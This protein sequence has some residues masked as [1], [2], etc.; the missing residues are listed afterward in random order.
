M[1]LVTCPDCGKKHSDQAKSCPECGRPYSAP[2]P[3]TPPLPPAKK[4]GGCL[5]TAL[6][7]V[8]LLLLVGIIAGAFQ[9]PAPE[10]V[11]LAP[12]TP[13]PEAEP[14]AEPAPAAPVVNSPQ[15]A[16]PEATEPEAQ[17]EEKSPEPEFDFTREDFQ[18]R[19]NAAAKE[20][21]FQYQLVASKSNDTDPAAPT[22]DGSIVWGG[23]IGKNSACSVFSDAGSKKIQSIL[24]F[25]GG[26][27]TQQDGLD[28]VITLGAII[29]AMS[30]ELAPDQ[31]RGVLEELN[32]LPTANFGKPAN[33]TRGKVTYESHANETAGL[34]FI[35]VKPAGEPTIIDVR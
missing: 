14:A 31:R 17:K 29:M 25:V 15:A 2:Q 19:F 18:K 24:F 22:P 20:L 23:T 5:K 1:A 26:G 21:Q 8:G 10:E 6:I 34:L 12:R 4:K 9:E 27:Q 33:A 30:P 11:T 16:T 28:A 32:L 13:A 35:T 3:Q 7:A